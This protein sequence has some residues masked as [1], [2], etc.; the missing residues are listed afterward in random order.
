MDIKWLTIPFN[1][2]TTS[3]LYDMLSLRTEVF[4]IEQVATYQ[5]ADYRDQ[6]CIHVLGYDGDTLVAHARVFPIGGYFE[7][8][9]IGRVVVKPSARGTGLGHVLIDK[10]IEAHNELNGKENSITISAQLRL[11]DFYEAHGFEKSGT[12]YDEDNIP[13]IHMTRKGE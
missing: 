13:H 2:L 9:C 8:G 6:K 12:C 5:D 11:R 4:I 1:E 7:D 10:A 3:Q